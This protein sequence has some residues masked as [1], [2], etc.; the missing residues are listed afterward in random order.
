VLGFA[1]DC[2]RS[3][4]AALQLADVRFVSQGLLVTLRKSKTDQHAQ[5]REIGIFRGRRQETCPVRTL[6]EWLRAR[7]RD[8]GPLFNRIDKHRLPRSKAGLLRRIHQRDY[9]A[10]VQLIGLDPRDYGAHSLRAG[11]V[12]AAHASGAS[13]SAIMQRSGHKSVQTLTQYIRHADPFQGR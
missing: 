3:E 11:M 6:R 10:A 4:L 5:G 13:D 7:G 12:T 9:E 1:S 2:R 8:A